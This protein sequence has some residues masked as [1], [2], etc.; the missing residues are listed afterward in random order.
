MEKF[1]QHE[2]VHY[3]IKGF[4]NLGEAVWGLYWGIMGIRFS[5]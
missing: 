1:M 4:P 2:I 3:R 5:H